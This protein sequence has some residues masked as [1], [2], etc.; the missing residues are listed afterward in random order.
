M[1][2]FFHG[3]LPEVM[4]K[5]GMP[6]HTV[7]V[8]RLQLLANG[9]HIRVI[10]ISETYMRK[11][12]V[13]LLEGKKNV[14]CFYAEK[15]K[16]FYAKSG[17]IVQNCHARRLRRNLV[18]VHDLLPSHV[19]VGFGKFQK[20]RRL[21][22]G[23]WRLASGEAKKNRRAKKIEMIFRIIVSPFFI[24]IIVLLH[25]NIITSPSLNVHYE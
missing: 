9:L 23:S 7:A 4:L 1:L 18:C 22:L 25:N 16:P 5:P 3:R 6:L 13:S 15:G 11:L 20:L 8:Q 14:V 2:C 12:A 10:G 24:L 17:L 21:R 19:P